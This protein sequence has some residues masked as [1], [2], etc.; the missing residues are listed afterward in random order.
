HCLARRRTM[1]VALLGAAKKFMFEDWEV[2]PG[3]KCRLCG[4]TPFLPNGKGRMSS[5]NTMAAA[6]LWVK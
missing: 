6:Y 2:D 5:Q 3:F 4:V 1:A